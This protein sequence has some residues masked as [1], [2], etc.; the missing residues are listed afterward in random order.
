MTARSA[1][2]AASAGHLRPRRPRARTAGRTGSRST[3]GRETGP[4][5]RFS[6]TFGADRYYQVA[7]AWPA[8]TEYHAWDEVT[9][10]DGS[11][12][13]GKDNQNN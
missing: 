1:S 11:V 9:N 10:A 3:S 5:S 7:G 6:K 4:N 12:T 13:P 8:G 2:P